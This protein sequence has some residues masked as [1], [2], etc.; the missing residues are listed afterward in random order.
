MLLTNTSPAWSLI[1]E[2]CL[3]PA[4]LSSEQA[5]AEINFHL[6]PNGMVMILSKAKDMPCKLALQKKK[7][8]PIFS[9]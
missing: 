4:R 9:A 6:L 2:A 1:S 8:A 7:T 3:K 5:E